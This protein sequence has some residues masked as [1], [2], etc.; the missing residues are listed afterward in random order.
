M[1]KNSE[2]NSTQPNDP[3]RRGINE[4]RPKNFLEI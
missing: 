3:M 2:G 4:W 1:K